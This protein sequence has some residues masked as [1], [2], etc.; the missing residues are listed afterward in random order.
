M[1]QLG[2]LKG[3]DPHGKSYRK[4]AK[5]NLTLYKHSSNVFTLI[6][7]FYLMTHTKKEVLFVREKIKTFLHRKNKLCPKWQNIQL[8]KVLTNGQEITKH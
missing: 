5:F 7:W 3:S 6:H 8:L 1:L 2:I 4:K